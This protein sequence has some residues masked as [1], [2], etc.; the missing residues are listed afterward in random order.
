[1]EADKVNKQRAYNPQ[2]CYI[3]NNHPYIRSSDTLVGTTSI[4]TATYV[5]MVVSTN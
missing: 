3:S 4:F 5:A 2:H 1:M